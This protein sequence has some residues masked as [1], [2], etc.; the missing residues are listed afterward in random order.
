MR[1]LLLCFVLLLPA[2]AY[3]GEAVSAPQTSIA[4]GASS[5]V[6]STR[7]TR[8][9][10]ILQNTSDT[11]IWCSL[12]GSGAAVGLGIGLDQQP[13]AG[14]PGGGIFFDV[15]TTIGAINC[16]HGSTGDKFLTLIEG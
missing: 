7:T 3:G 11:A 1:I 2:F 8:K 13:G 9:L 14:R 15:V 6:V 16:I 10:L 4:I 12:D 5:T